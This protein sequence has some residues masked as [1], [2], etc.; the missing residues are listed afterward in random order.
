MGVLD[1]FDPETMAQLKAL[2]Q[3]DEDQKKQAMNAGLLSAGLGMLANNRGYGRS[4]AFNNAVGYGGLQGVNAYQDSIQRMQQDQKD[5]LSMGMML[6]K[7]KRE[8]AGYDTMTSGLRNVM[9]PGQSSYQ[10]PTKTQYQFNPDGETSFNMTDPNALTAYSGL[11]KKIT[12]KIAQGKKTTADEQSFL[13]EFQKHVQPVQV[14]VPQDKSAQLRDLSLATSAY[15]PEQA[16]FLLEASKAYQPVEEKAGSYYRDYNG[17]TRYVGDPTK[18]LTMADGKIVQM[19]GAGNIAAMEGQKVAAQEAAKAPYAQP[20]VIKGVGPNGSDLVI[21]A[22]ML[23][24]I[25]GA[26][27]SRAPGAQQGE[28]SF[29]E[30]WVKGTYQPIQ[31]A[32]TSAN[33][34]ISQVQT[35]RNIPIDTGWGKEALA[36]G[37]NILTGLGIAPEN[38][39]IFAANAQK[40]QQVAMERLWVTLNAAKGPQTEGDADRARQTFV[41]LKNTPEANQF[42]A[43]LVEATANRDLTKSSFYQDGYQIAKQDGN[44]GKVD[45]QWRKVQ[46]SIWDDPVMLKWK[47]K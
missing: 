12:D 35:L 4:Q 13:E 9:N 41:S 40:F 7:M 21:P 47:R 17:N 28:N 37:A 25:S 2:S 46:R 29:N 45:Q 26:M 24:G 42:I 14:P 23:P 15:M 6:S 34:M 18:G 5:K 44:F 39:K 36:N 10:Q 8:Q 20:T 1:M 32:A 11:A 16:K 19:P 33:K 22:T 38:A 30:N 27:T 31:D 3:P 43:D